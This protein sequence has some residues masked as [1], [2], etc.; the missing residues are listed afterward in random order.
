MSPELID[1]WFI[2]THFQNKWNTKYKVRDPIPC[3][4]TERTIDIKE[5]T[6]IWNL[7]TSRILSFNFK[8]VKSMNEYLV[9]DGKN[10]VSKDGQQKLTL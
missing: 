3:D 10:Y 1:F 4:I 7:S 9:I 6:L 5:F 2:F 8:E